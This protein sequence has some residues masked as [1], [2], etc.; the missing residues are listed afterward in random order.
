MTENGR[1][2]VRELCQSQLPHRGSLNSS[3]AGPARLIDQDPG[4]MGEC[5]LYV[6]HQ[7]SPVG[8]E[9]SSQIAGGRSRELTV[10]LR[11]QRT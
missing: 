6:I 10:D 3:K 8:A 1:D 11:V 7:D 2:P 4:E 9:Y 5:C